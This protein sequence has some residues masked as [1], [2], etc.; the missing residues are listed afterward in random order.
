MTALDGSLIAHLRIF[1]KRFHYVI[2][3]WTGVKKTWTID[4]AGKSYAA[5]CGALNATSAD[6]P[7]LTATTPVPKSGDSSCTRLTCAYYGNGNG[8]YSDGCSGYI[9]C[10][11]GGYGGY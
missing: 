4:I 8:T 1:I 3:Q 10:G 5:E 6:V 2:A 7:T 9:V 11:T